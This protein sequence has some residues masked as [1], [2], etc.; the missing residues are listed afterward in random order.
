MKVRKRNGNEEDFSLAK[1]LNA[2]KKANNSVEKEK[3]MDDEKINQIVD[4]VQK[5]IKNFSTV[6]VETIQDFV[7]KALMNKKLIRHKMEL[8]NPKEGSDVFVLKG[9]NTV[10][11]KQEEIISFNE[12]EN[13]QRGRLRGRK[14]VRK[15]KN[16]INENEK[17]N[18]IKGSNINYNQRE[19]LSKLRKRKER[20]A[21]FNNQI[22]SH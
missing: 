8:S 17:Q 1:I 13:K 12:N 20:I 5:K 7:E 21:Q 18:K 2:V 16:V 4:F 6:D 14:P 15:D 19:E 22:K 10:E 11:E 3:R 9:S